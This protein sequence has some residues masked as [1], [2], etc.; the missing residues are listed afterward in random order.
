M[1]HE[2][3]DSTHKSCTTNAGVLSTVLRQGQKVL[4]SSTGP[5][6]GQNSHNEIADCVNLSST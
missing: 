6:T 3:L 5:Q 4:G 1:R 2:F